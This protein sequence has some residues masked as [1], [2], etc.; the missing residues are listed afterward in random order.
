[1]TFFKIFVFLE[2]HED[3]EM[4]REIIF[5][6]EIFSSDVING[7]FVFSKIFKDDMKSPMTI[8]W[9]EDSLGVSS[10]YSKSAFNCFDFLDTVALG[11]KL[12]L[13]VYKSDHS[14]RMQANYNLTTELFSPY[15]LSRT[16]GP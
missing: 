5:C 3:E 7:R 1:M 2:T 10:Q 15:F 13:I 16:C 9:V 4:M 12:S 8:D 6:L 11:G 14:P